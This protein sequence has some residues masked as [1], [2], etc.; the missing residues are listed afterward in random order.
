MYRN[1]IYTSFIFMQFITLVEKSTNYSHIDDYS[2]SLL[3][4]TSNCPLQQ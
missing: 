2:V 4:A 3:Q 1:T